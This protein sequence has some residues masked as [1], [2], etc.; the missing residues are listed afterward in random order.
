MQLSFLGSG[1]AFTVGDNFHSNI[2]IEASDKKRMLI[3]CGSDARHS[4]SKKGFNFLDLEAV[5]IS[6]LHADHSG[7]LEWL[8]FTRKFAPPFKKVRLFIHESLVG[9]IWEHQLRASLQPLGEISAQLETYFDVAPLKDKFEWEN[10]QF[11]LVKTH[12]I[13]DANTWVDSYGLF[14]ELGKT[15]IYLT[16]DTQFFP[17]YMAP[18]YEKADVIFH[19]CETSIPPSGVH[20]SYA[21]LKSLPDSI[22]SKMWLYHFNPGALPDALRDGFLGFVKC[23]QEFDY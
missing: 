12:H 2:L 10:V 3:D 20:A 5:Y 16:T 1:S 23:G 7:G 19:D 17:D 21:N 6:H 9:P 22:R 15:K 11:E 8:A 4:L 18:Y 13:Q 14:F